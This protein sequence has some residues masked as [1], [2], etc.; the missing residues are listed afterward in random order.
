VEGGKDQNSSEQ[1]FCNNDFLTS[2][3]I[4]TPP[5]QKYLSI[6]F[7]IFVLFISCGK[8]EG[9]HKNQR[10]FYYWKT[11]FR[12][13][14]EEKDALRA[15]HIDK[16]YLRFL[17]VDWSEAD[18]KVIPK[19]KVVVKD[20]LPLPVVPVIYVTNKTFLHLQTGDINGLAEN[21]ARAVR[22][23]S[24]KNQL[25]F[26]ELQIDCDWS[27]KTRSKYFLFLEKLKNNF[28]GVSISCTIR[29]H[30]IKYA[31]ITG[32][33]PV[34]RGMLMFY[35]MGKL[36][37]AAT[38]NS[39]YNESD[40]KKYTDYVHRYPLPL[41]V[42]LPVFEWCVHSRENRIEGLINK[43]D[44]MNFEADTNFSKQSERTF[45][46]RNSFFTKG[47]YI[48]KGDLFKLEKITEKD[49]TSAVDL[50]SGKLRKEKRTVALFDLDKV[51]ILRHDKKL[52]EEVYDTFD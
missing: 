32:I 11:T 43:N 45:I 16:L 13:S 50:I 36:N 17:D 29:L 1:G 20:A 31:E 51:N 25:Q 2:I 14:Q 37:S 8:K 35:N 6:F 42:V 23:V 22:S 41:D 40:A 4:F 28:P 15:L 27:D 38:V 44:I 48:K 21:C 39:I 3:P 47:R 19:G 52:L 46:A 24:D 34:H 7:A 33:P 30:Q 10:A 9:N 49:L 5:M 26:S 12:L 18:S